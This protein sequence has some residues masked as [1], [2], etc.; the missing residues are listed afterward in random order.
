MTGFLY[1][2]WRT[3]NMIRF[4]GF[5]LFFLFLLS[6]AQAR[7]VIVLSSDFAGNTVTGTPTG[8]GGNITWSTRPEVSM[9]AAGNLVSLSGYNFR[10]RGNLSD[11]NNISVDRNLNTMGETEN[12]RGFQVD[13]TVSAG[14]ALERLTVQSGHVNN[15]GNKQVNGSTLHYRILRTTDSSLVATGS[16]FVDY[17][18]SGSEV[19]REIV[20]PLSGD[21]ETGTDYRLEVGMNNLVGGGGFAIY[22]GITLEG[23]PPPGGD[24]DVA[25]R[26]NFATFQ[27]AVASPVS[28]TYRAELALDGIAS[29]FHAWRSGNTSGARTLEIT[30]PR[31][32][33]L[34]SAHVYSGILNA[35]TTQVYSSFVFQ[36]HNGTTWVDIPGSTV[37]GNSQP[38]RIIP[39]SAPVTSDRFRFFSNDTSNRAIREIALFPPNVVG[40]VEQGFALGTGVRLNLAYGRPVTASSAEGAN[41]AVHAVDGYADDSSR[42]QSTAGPAGQT[43]E[44]DLLDVH[45]LGSAHVYTGHGGENVLTQ[46]AL[47]YWDGAAWVTIPG[48]TITGNSSDALVVS[49]AET[50]ATSRVRLRTTDDSSAHVRELLF[51]PPRV[52][53]YPPGQDVRWM[54]P[55]VAVW[56]DFSDDTYR[57]R[58]HPTPDRRLALVDGAAI[59]SNNTAGAAALDW[60]LLL[61][62]RDGSY[63]IRHAAT[64]LCL[65]AADI[66][67][68]PG[69]TV[70]AE[71]YSGLPHQDWFLE[72][73]SPTR[74]RILNAHSG[75]ALESEGSN[76]ALGTPLVL[77][78]P[79][80]SRLQQWDAS[81]QTHHPKKGIAATGPNL[82]DNAALMPSSWSYTWGRQ[83]SRDFPLL[84]ATHTFNPMQ[85]GN[86]NWT[87]GSNLGPLE[88]LRNDLQAQSK[89]VHL[90]G[91][92][93]PDALGQANMTVG[94]AINR[95]PRLLSMDVPLLSPAPASKNTT[96]GWLVDFYDEAEELGYRVDYTGFHWYA[97]PNSDA[98]IANLQQAYERWQ[99]P[100]WLTE[101]S[102][103]RW[104]GSGGQWTAADNY[105]FLAEFLWRAESLP[106]LKRYSLFQF[107]EN[108]A[109]ANQS[110]PDPPEA[111]RSNTR[112]ADGSLTAFGELYASWDAITDVLPHK[113]YHIHNKAAYR[114]LQNPGSNSTP[115]DAVHSVSP[116]TPTAGNQWFL[117]PGTT[118]N[119]VRLVS[120]RDG[121]RLRYWNGTYVGLAAATNIGAQ[122]EWRLVPHEHG[123]YFVEHP[124]TGTRLRLNAEGTPIHG[125]GAATS[126]EYKWRFVNALHPEPVAPPVAPPVVSTQAFT[127]R[128]E[129][130]WT[131]V[132]GASSYR[133]E[134]FD[135][136]TSTWQVV[137]QEISGTNWAEENLPFETEQRYRVIA[138]NALGD[139]P[140][141]NSTPATTLHPFQRFELWQAHFLRELPAHEHGFHADPDGDGIVNLLEFAYGQN[142]RL[143]AANPFRIFAAQAG[144]FVIEFPWNWRAGGLQWQIRHGNDLSNR[145]GWSVAA[146]DSV[147][148]TREGDVDLIRLT[149]PL[150][151]S[152]SQF[153]ILEV[154]HSE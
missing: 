80:S 90:L 138:L 20:F 5:F 117:I 59:F 106:W 2:V 52:G 82:E 91:F 19:F 111:P 64:G 28:S 131:S 79:S 148:S 102:V 24:P 61:N 86:F 39:F 85:W 107:V 128:I 22:D 57:I 58:I 56:D 130:S 151:N 36:F 4:F 17:G 27:E 118:E 60:Q 141:S 150:P 49:F 100:V 71:A 121:R 114:R 44:I 103:V 6:S 62:Y 99:R 154:L 96:Q 81:R 127:D 147:Q 133:V 1:P 104:E 84:P 8:T 11:E 69:T 122:S 105:N 116:E 23:W 43:L 95:W 16:T 9:L 55:P 29:N 75:L 40:G 140:A 47:D 37:T 48:A 41:F 32:V 21:L 144:P 97:N 120:T 115:A 142:P 13:F 76:V 18:P 53:G 25:R 132:P 50:I 63:R 129:L 70:I 34:A 119:T 33:T 30:Y 92:N 101:F 108:A 45:A 145:S 12:L 15:E 10:R 67:G 68:A 123:W 88:V 153:F 124:Q 7:P 51:F 143:P 35:S 14:F 146:Y 126:D 87:H 46:F 31:P 135:P 136:Q 93:E 125:S 42:W 78:P 89:P 54:V 113:S 73:V 65:A 149:L 74:F 3:V 26:F 38:E 139:S 110:A 152:S 94:T 72:F 109:G 112:R 134:R 137:A 77:H 66:S 98:L 83:N